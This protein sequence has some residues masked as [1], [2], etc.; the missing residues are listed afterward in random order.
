MTKP[1]SQPT[2]T[3]ARSAKWRGNHKPGLCMKFDC[4]NRDKKCDEC[5]MIGGGP[6]QYETEG[7]G[8]YDK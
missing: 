1:I 2:H 5:I 8:K 4:Q 7:N 6:T 3:E